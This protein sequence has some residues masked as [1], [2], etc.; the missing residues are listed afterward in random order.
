LYESELE[1]DATTTFC[2][3]RGG[4]LALEEELGVVLFFF[5]IVYRG[6]RLLL[7]DEDRNFALLLLPAVNVTGIYPRVRKV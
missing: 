7:S 5:M 1:E 2:R 4:A 6:P 3:F